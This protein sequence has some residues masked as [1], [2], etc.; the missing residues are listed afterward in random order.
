MMKKYLTALGMA[1]S[2]FCR[3]PIPFRKW[4]ENVRSYMLLFLP[5]IGLEMGLLW[6]GLH[7]LLRTMAASEW[8]YGFV[9]CV[10]PYLFTGFIHMDGFMDVADA[11]SSWKEL[12]ERR[13]ILK[14][15]HVG[16]FAVIWCVFIILAG[17]SL[18]ASMP[19]DMDGW[20][21][22][23]IPVLSRCCSY[24]SVL[25]L[26]PMASSQYAKTQR[27]PKYHQ[28]IIRSLIVICIVLGC[29][30]GENTGRCVIGVLAGYL[31]ALW[32]SYRMLDG[33]N[34]DVSGFCLTISELCGLAAYILL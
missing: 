2:M 31:I 32:K 14:D 27:S 24:L 4:D 21:L 3:I 17:F 1:Q 11:I 33:M 30:L 6:I 22:I 20:G 10:F 19:E 29:I 16:S 7:Y 5:L 15:P 28:W 8:I 34:G 12:K 18:F 25:G 26:K 23:F 9:M 13:A